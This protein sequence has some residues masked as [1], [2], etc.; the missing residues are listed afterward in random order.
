MGLG[1]GA[2]DSEGAAIGAG[3]EAHA[4]GRAKEQ[5]AAGSI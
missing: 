5:R 3:R 2:G 4:L 1:D